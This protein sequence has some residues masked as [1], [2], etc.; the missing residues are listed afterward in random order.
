[1]IGYCV[2]RIEGS[3]YWVLVRCWVH[4]PFFFT[5][6]DDGLIWFRYKKTI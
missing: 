1:M 3:E 5:G 4:I 6:S 2:I